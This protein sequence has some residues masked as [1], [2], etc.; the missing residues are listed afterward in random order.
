LFAAGRAG[1]RFAVRNSGALAVVE[2]AGEHA[3]EYMTGGIVV[4]LGKTGRNFAAGMS[5]GVAYVLDMDGVFPMRCNTELVELQRIDDADEMEAVRTIVS[6]HAKKTRSWRAAQILAEWSRMQRRFWRI[7]PHG[8]TTSACDFVEAN[9]YPSEL[10][11]AP[12]H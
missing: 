3:C 2:G 8:T 5:A 1:E 12:H 6:W 9:L 11:A 7:L 4:V 10:V